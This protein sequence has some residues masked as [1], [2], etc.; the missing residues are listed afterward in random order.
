VSINILINS[1]KAKMIDLIERLFEG[2]MQCITNN[3]FVRFARKEGQTDN[4]DFIQIS[5]LLNNRGIHG[6]Q[7]CFSS[8]FCPLIA[9]NYVK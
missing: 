2:K 6:M 7:K 1:K 4:I 8:F 5:S 9:Q 3:M